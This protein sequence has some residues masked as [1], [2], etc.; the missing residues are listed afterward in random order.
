MW[1][2]FN[3]CFEAISVTKYL[4]YIFH[5]WEDGVDKLFPIHLNEYK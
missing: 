4:K 5:F 3:Y 1:I 2:Q